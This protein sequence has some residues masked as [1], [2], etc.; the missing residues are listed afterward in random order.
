MRRHG[1]EKPPP[2]CRRDDASLDYRIDGTDRIVAVGESWLR[3]AAANGAPSLTREAVVGQ[4][5]WDFVAGRETREIWTALLGRVR[6]GRRI[7][8]LPFRCDGPAVRRFL[9]VEVSARD[10][11]AV[12]IATR[13]LREE[14][15]PPVQLLDPEAERSSEILR[16]C[17]WCKRVETPEQGWLETEAAI[18]VLDLFGRRQVPKVSH[19]MCLDCEGRTLEDLG[20]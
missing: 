16:L 12:E 17:S 10:D 5:L 20:D 11:G 1:Q 7:A 9:T 4:S 13:L 3:F 8:R 6:A 18:E 19:G 2:D 15:R 14:V